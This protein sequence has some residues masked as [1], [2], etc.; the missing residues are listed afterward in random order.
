MLKNMSQIQ[1]DVTHNVVGQ[2]CVFRHNAQVWAKFNLYFNA[3]AHL[4]FPRTLLQANTNA[5]T[6]CIEEE[7]KYFQLPNG[8][9]T[10]KFMLLT[11]NRLFYITDNEAQTY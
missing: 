2:P 5:I 9:I 7:V 8:D 3:L 11:L 1:I 10:K 6:L 4:L